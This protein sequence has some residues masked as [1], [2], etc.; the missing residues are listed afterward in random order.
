MDENEVPDDLVTAQEASAISL[1]SAWT[2]RQMA[3]EEKV[4][5]FQRD[6]RSGYWY[7]RAEM[8]AERAKFRRVR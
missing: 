3:E 1:H 8:E 4:R 5:Q 2:L 6:G 7:S